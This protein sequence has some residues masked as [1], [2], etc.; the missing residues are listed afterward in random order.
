MPFAVLQTDLNP[1]TLEQLQR[2]FRH[3]PGLTASDGHILGRD[4]YGVL[5]KNFPAEHAVALQG[6]L[7]IEG[8]ETEIVDESYL[9]AMPPGKQI[10][11]LD[12]VPEHLLIYDPLGRSFPLPWPHVMLIA[13][14]MARVTE[15]VR[16]PEE[17]RK[18]RF[19]MNG[20]AYVEHRTE[21]HSREERNEQ[22]VAEIIISGA[23]LRYSINAERFNFMSL[24]G[25][26]TGDATQDFAL[27]IQDLA[28]FATNAVL[29][30]GA[31][32]IRRNQPFAY[33][34]RNAFQ[35]EIVWTLWQ[36]KKRA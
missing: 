21:Y 29:N 12:C 10:N 34:T 20:G 13:A 28:R 36:M 7:R 31:E 3:V 25:R 1:P 9:P 24:G 14:G 30:R 19:N 6:A 2:A 22:C 8:V 32:A 27:L 5:V 18:V 15:F 26:R 11:R 23:V 17:S 4:A 35:E 33:P 16:V